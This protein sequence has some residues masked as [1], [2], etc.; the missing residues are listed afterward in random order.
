MRSFEKIDILSI[1]KI[2]KGWY[3]MVTENH[4]YICYIVFVDDKWVWSE[5]SYNLETGNQQNLVNRHCN[6]SNVVE[7]KKISMREVRKY[8][9]KYDEKL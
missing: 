9:P 7:I 4:P 2:N 5:Y 6:T 8:F 1:N 3:K